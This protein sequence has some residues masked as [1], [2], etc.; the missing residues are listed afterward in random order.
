MPTWET[1][2]YEDCLKAPH[3]G[4]ECSGNAG[5]TSMYAFAVKL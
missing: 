1:S 5:V 2:L 3:V 4:E